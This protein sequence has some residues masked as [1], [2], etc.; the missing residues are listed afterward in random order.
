[1]VPSPHRPSVPAAASRRRQPNN[2]REIPRRGRRIVL[3]VAVRRHPGVSI[4]RRRRVAVPRRRG[5]TRRSASRPG[6]ARALLARGR[7]GWRPAVWACWRCRGEPSGCRGPRCHIGRPRRYRYRRVPGRPVTNAIAAGTVR[8]I[9]RLRGRR[10][11]VGVRGGSQ[12]PVV[13]SGSVA[14]LA[15]PRDAGGRAAQH[16]APPRG[17]HRRLGLLVAAELHE[18]AARLGL[19]VGATAARVAPRPAAAAASATAGEEDGL[20]VAVHVEGAAA[21]EDE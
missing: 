10:P 12:E 21:R 2:W 16:D 13:H 7:S 3:G 6:V 11:S 8:G 20:D 18:R 15:R 9:R 1:M 19:G 4:G 17:Q 14:L 5:R